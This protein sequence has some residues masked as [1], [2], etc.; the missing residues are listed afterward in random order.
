M[1]SMYYFWKLRFHGQSEPE[2]VIFIECHQGNLGE[3]TI[4][5]S[6]KKPQKKLLEKRKRRLLSVEDKSPRAR[7]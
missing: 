6:L 1:S 5:G 7:K 2:T 4:P 3:V